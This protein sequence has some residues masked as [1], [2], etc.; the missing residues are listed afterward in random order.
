MNK[1]KKHI[2]LGFF[3]LLVG[4]LLPAYKAEAAKVKLSS[5]KLE[6]TVGDTKT[7]Q[8]KN[9]TKK[10]KWSVTSGG[11]LISLKEKKK[12]GVKIVAVKK[13]TAK[14]CAKI[15]KKKYTCTVTVK[16]A[17]KKSSSDQKALKALIKKVGKGTKIS[18]NMNNK[19]QY[20]WNS[21]GKLVEIDW[22]NC[23]IKGT[24][25]FAGL[26]SLTGIFVHNNKILNFSVLLY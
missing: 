26:A 24:V 19:K 6:V 23:N 21:K 13:G 18:S 10:V 15:G 17:V 22:E 7:L 3:L 20:E 9:N 11:K 2:I 1:M 5:K 14:V 12:T 8:L 25:S 16:A 4:C